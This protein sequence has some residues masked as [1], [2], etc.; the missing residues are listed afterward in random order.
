MVNVHY[1]DF[2]PLFGRWTD[3]YEPVANDQFYWTI[4][5][6]LA[7][8]YAYLYLA[9]R[10]FDYWVLTPSELIHHRGVMGNLN[11]IRASKIGVEMEIPD[12]F[13]LLL[14]R[15]GRLILH[16]EEGR[17]IILENVHNIHEQ[18]RAL[19]R[20]LNVTLVHST[21]PSHGT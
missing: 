1:W 17:T 3:G 5:G 8:L 12:V 18:V 15:S 19:Q 14:F 11:V 21:G 13:E 7:L 6:G 16:P 4:G 2:W 9:R 10:S 20:C